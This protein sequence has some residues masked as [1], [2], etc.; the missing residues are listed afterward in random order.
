MT[1]GKSP[2]DFETARLALFEEPPISV[3]ALD[4]QS[5]AG[6]GLLQDIYGEPALI[7]R[8]DM[9]DRNVYRQGKA[10]VNFLIVLL[11]AVG[12]IVAV[13]MLFFLEKWILSRLAYLNRGI[14]DIGPAGS[15]VTRLIVTGSDEISNLTR[16]LNEMLEALERYQYQL[17]DKN[18][19]F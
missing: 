11:A 17:T 8:V 19:E 4:E 3:Q 6:Y 15:L 10:T 7:L 13:L 9:T 2:P 18:E 14:R 12:V 5:V 1:T 16:T